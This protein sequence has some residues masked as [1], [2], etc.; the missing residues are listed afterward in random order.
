MT[1]LFYMQ[2]VPLFHLYHCVM[3]VK[4]TFYKPVADFY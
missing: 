1:T 4:L 2:A 3:M